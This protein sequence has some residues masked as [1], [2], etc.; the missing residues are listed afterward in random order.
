MHSGCLFQKRCVQAHMCSGAYVFRYVFGYVF[1]I[2]TY[3]FRIRI[4]VFRYVFKVKSEYIS[5][6]IY[7]YVFRKGMFSEIFRTHIKK[8][9][10]HIWT[11]TP[12]VFRIC[13]Q[14]FRFTDAAR[15]PPC[16]TP[17]TTTTTNV[18]IL[19][20]HTPP[21][22]TIHPQSWDITNTHH[23]KYPLHTPQAYNY[24]PSTS[25]PPSP[26]IWMTRTYKTTPRSH[27][28]WPK[29]WMT[30]TSYNTSNWMLHTT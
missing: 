15:T 27:T 12:Y 22:N 3:V 5:E 18:T 2:I 28:P 16:S 9:W 17:T 10:K 8:T 21:T 19:Q 13:F 14:I 20:T 11:H 6:Q 7:K 4:Y 25:H 26:S 29:I 23:N 30:H 1:R 24:L